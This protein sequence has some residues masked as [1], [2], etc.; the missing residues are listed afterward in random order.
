[1]FVTDN[2][3]KIVDIN[4]LDLAFV[5]CQRFSP[6]FRQHASLFRVLFI[7]YFMSD[8]IFIFIS[9]FFHFWPKDG[10]LITYFLDLGKAVFRNEAVKSP[11]D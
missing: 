7:K 2:L 8:N 10:N 1:M 9:Y 6:L 5:D 4:K 11:L 3:N